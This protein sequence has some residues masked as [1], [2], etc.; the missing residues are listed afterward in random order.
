MTISRAYT[1]CGCTIA[2]FTATVIPP[3]GHSIM[4]LVFDAGFHDAAGQSVR[5]GVLIENNDPDLP[6]LEIWIEANVSNN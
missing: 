1:T 4:T 5:R 2:D 3:G 6:Q